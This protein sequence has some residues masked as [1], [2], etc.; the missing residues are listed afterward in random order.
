M[1]AMPEPVVLDRVPGQEGA[2][3]FLR[4]AAVRPHHDYLLAGPEEDRKS[5]V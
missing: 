5:V 1:A 3:A 4:K 2:M